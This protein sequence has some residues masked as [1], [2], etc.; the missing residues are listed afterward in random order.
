MQTR[1]MATKSLSR[2]RQKGASM[3][4]IGFV[5]VVFGVIGKVVFA[6]I[7]FYDEYSGILRSVNQLG[8]KPDAKTMSGGQ[9]KGALLNNLSI[10][11]VRSV[12]HKNFKEHFY[13]KKTGS[14]RDI[15]I[16]YQREAPLF[17]NIFLVVKFDETVTL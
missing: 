10:N 5:L 14:G 17:K 6:L 8:D 12:T 9:L 16:K 11:S 7:P 1:I 2:L 3:L 13:L 15:I 4:A